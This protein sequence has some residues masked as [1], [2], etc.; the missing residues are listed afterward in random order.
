MKYRLSTVWVGLPFILAG[1]L[2]GGEVTDETLNPATMSINA[3]G[4]DLLGKGVASDANTLLSPYSI[5]S[6]LAITYAGA[7]G[8]TRAEMAKVLHFGDDEAGLH[9]SLARSHSLRS[10]I[11]GVVGS[12]MA[13]SLHCCVVTMTRTKLFV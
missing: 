5:Q 9:R 3:L 12:V 1:A 8:G 7:D 13:F 10:T 2:L 11:P 4:L 6:A